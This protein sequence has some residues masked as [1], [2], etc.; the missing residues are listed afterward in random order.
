MSA[1]LLF[2]SPLVVHFDFGLEAP[3]EEVRGCAGNDYLLDGDDTSGSS[4]YGGDGNDILI[5]EFAPKTGRDH[6]V[7]GN[8]N[9]VLV[10][11][12]NAEMSGG[13]GTDRFVLA[14]GTRGAFITDMDPATESVDLWPAVS[15]NRDY[16]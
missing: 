1:I 3:I 2:L 8:G 6:L 10:G 15:Y 7:G 13:A 4:L 14:W 16:L 5:L 11:N 12:G 9:V